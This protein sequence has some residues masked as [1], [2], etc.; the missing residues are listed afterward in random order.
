MDAFLFQ[1]ERQCQENVFE[2]LSGII[3]EEGGEG[4]GGGVEE[5]GNLGGGDDGESGLFLWRG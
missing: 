2:E 5:L 1:K 3:G 4:A